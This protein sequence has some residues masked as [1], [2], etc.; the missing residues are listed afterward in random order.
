MDTILVVDDEPASLRLLTE[1]LE[2]EGYRVCP[3]DSGDLALA[4]IASEVI[5]LDSRRCKDAGYERIRVLP[6]R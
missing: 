5:G 3:A 6:P 4:S 1:I 2:P